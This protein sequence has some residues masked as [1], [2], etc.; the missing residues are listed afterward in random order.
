MPGIGPAL[1]VRAD[2][3]G[4][5]EALRAVLEREVYPVLAATRDECDRLS[6]AVGNTEL[7]VSTE[8]GGGDYVADGTNDEVEIQQA[9]DA[10]SAVGEQTGATAA[11]RLVPGTY[12]VSAPIHLQAGVSL[13]GPTE[14][15][16]VIL[17]KSDFPHETSSHVVGAFPLSGWGDAVD[18][19]SDAAAGDTSVAVVGSAGDFVLRETYLI[20]DDLEWDDSA[21]NA[22]PRYRGELVK[23]LKKG[24][25][26]SGSTGSIIGYTESTD[27]VWFEGSG[28]SDSMVGQ[29]LT[30]TGAA[31]ANHNGNYTIVSVSSDGKVVEFYNARSG[32]TAT[33]A[34]NG[35]ISWD[36]P[37][38][39]VYGA[40]RDAYTTSNN[41]KIHWVPWVDSVSVEG[42]HFEQEAALGT[43]H[44]T[45]GGNVPMIGMR[46]CRDVTIDRCTVNRNDGPAVVL[47]TVQGAT[48]TDLRARDLFDYSGVGDAFGYGVLVGGASED[49]VISACRVDACR[50]G[51][52][53]GHWK[54]PDATQT[55]D[56][57]TP[58]TNRGVARGVV[59]TGCVVSHAT[60]AAY[61]THAEAEGWAMTGNKAQNC[62]N[63]GFFARGR[64]CRIV[65]NH[66]ENCAGGVHVGT[67]ATSAAS[68][69]G[70]GTVVDS[71]TIRH[72]RNTL[73]A[74]ADEVNQNV[75]GSGGGGGSGMGVSLARTDHCTVSNNHIEFCGRAGIRLRKQTYRC[76]FFGNVVLD[77]NQDDNSGSTGSGIVMPDPISVT[78][79]ITAVSGTT[80]TVDISAS[81][82]NVYASDVGT[83]VSM[84]GFASG[85][86]NGIFKITAVPTDTTFQF[87]NASAVNGETG[88]Y[89]EEMSSYNV[90]ARNFVANRPVYTAGLSGTYPPTAN[91]NERDVEGH[92]K[93]GIRCSGVTAWNNLFYDNDLFAM[94]T[95]ATL[96]TGT[97]SVVRNNRTESQIHPIHEHAFEFVECAVLE[98]PSASTSW[99]DVNTEVSTTKAVRIWFDIDQYPAD[100]RPGF[101]RNV[102]IDWVLSTDAT[103]LAN[104]PHVRLIIQ[105]TGSSIT[106]SGQGHDGTTST[107][108]LTGPLTV[109]GSNG[110]QSGATEYRVQ[111]R[112][113]TDGTNLIRVH[114]ARIIVR[115]E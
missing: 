35:S 34:N 70:S 92:M 44:L 5:P 100:L 112:H 68:F 97:N 23:A 41:A 85:G 109:G 108:Y 18:V 64:G 10:A 33:D 80:V 20:S 40:L 66:V 37:S 30:I 47:E 79:T 76:S 25:T 3:E 89:E 105:G 26:S 14:G 36:G 72:C 102:Y 27:R 28:F 21:G 59:I 53:S 69:L 67:S 51:F 114:Q 9:I 101:T 50:H 78:A 7:T 83:Y 19:R 24:A 61:S 84:T 29:T 115:Y 4:R 46:F 38:L 39:Q 1:R 52:D 22:T 56:G 106:G 98:P 81:D 73:T 31:T 42:I 91:A 86:N 60:D 17:V 103:P 62:D 8:R 111:G 45:T 74:A 54:G 93:Y 15:R 63:Y 99:L 58:V 12:H 95:G 32:L 71:N 75:T 82:D 65:G 11:V 96:I 107:R 43:M 88:N 90:F 6:R 87:E 48:I 57:T 49:V 55:T 104:D 110:L 94:E 13:K 113:P 77:C 16:A 2:L